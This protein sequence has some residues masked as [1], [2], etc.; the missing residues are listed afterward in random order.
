MLV[1]AR[2]ATLV[3]LPCCCCC[4]FVSAS[5]LG[6]K[7]ALWLT[8][9]SAPTADTGSAAAADGAAG[10]TASCCCTAPLSWCCKWT[11]LGLPG[12]ELDGVDVGESD[13]CPVEQLA[14]ESFRT[15]VT[16]LG[17]RARTGPIRDCSR[18]WD[19]GFCTCCLAAENVA[20]PVLLPAV[21]GRA[22]RSPAAKPPGGEVLSTPGPLI[23]PDC[24]RHIT[25][26]TTPPPSKSTAA[27]GTA[28]MG[29]VDI[30]LT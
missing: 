10:D 29:Q 6:C 23:S 17:T 26:H 18:D 24:S 16:W 7:L 21:E 4:C 20:E 5:T 1:A 11:R 2:A 13:G 25:W 8:P 22:G 15:S 19:P 28:G 30:K 12:M 14:V 27:Q 3:L 9:T